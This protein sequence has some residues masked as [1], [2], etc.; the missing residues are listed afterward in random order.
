MFNTYISNETLSKHIRDPNWVIIDCRFSL[1]DTELGR[2]KY[3]SAHIPGAFYAHLDEDLSGPVLME[4]TGRHP[5]PRAN[6][7][8]QRMASWGIQPESQVV[9][10]DDAAGMIAGRLWWM[11]HWLGHDAAAVLD[12]GWPH[13][14]DNQ[15]KIETGIRDPIVTGSPY[16]FDENPEMQEHFQTIL[17]MRIDERE[18]VLWDSRAPARY[19]GENEPIDFAAGHISGAGNA[20]NNAVIQEDG[21]ARSRAELQAHFGHILGKASAEDQVFYCGSGVSACR[22]ILGMVHAGLPMPKLYVGSWSE[23]IARGAHR[24]AN[25]K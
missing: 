23:W 3:A 14:L 12:G 16:P 10:Y 20:P 5:L 21:L 25:S 17:A 15:S 8:A 13:W 18:R 11:L 4:K 24:P 9:I 6:I 7:F 1:A 2:R 22:N 19:R